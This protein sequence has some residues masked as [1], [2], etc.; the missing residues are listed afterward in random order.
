M[1]GVVGKLLAI[2]KA[3]QDVRN[4]VPVLR[5][6]LVRGDDIGKSSLTTREI[7]REFRH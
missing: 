4:V 5:F 2:R 6:Y 1:D 3:G 7:C